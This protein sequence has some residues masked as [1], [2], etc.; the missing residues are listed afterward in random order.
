MPNTASSLEDEEKDFKKKKSQ[1]KFFCSQ[2][3]IKTKIYQSGQKSLIV[4]NAST[5]AKTDA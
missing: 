1:F 2:K 4:Y 5:F 3:N